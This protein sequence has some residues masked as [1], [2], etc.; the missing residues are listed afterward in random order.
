MFSIR[1]YV[2]KLE[3]TQRQ[4]N[5]RLNISNS[6]N[7]L[8]SILIKDPPLLSALNYNGRAQ[9]TKFCRAIPL[10]IHQLTPASI[11]ISNF[12]TVRSTFFLWS[13]RLLGNKFLNDDLLS[14]VCGCALRLRCNALYCIVLCLITPWTCLLYHIKTKGVNSAYPHFDFRQCPLTIHVNCEETLFLCW[15]NR[16]YIRKLIGTEEF[17]TW[18]LWN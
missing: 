12:T 3:V 9:F 6:I 2:N 5:V 7:V 17:E 14:M 16:A 8:S 4:N 18:P 11:S 10:R 1:Y 13:E 15:T